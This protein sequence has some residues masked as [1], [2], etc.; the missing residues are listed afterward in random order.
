VTLTTIG[1]GDV[2]PLSGEV[3]MLAVLEGM[4][5]VMYVAITVALLVNSYK[6]QQNNQR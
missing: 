3:R 2:V 5:G 6:Q 1:Y 4:V